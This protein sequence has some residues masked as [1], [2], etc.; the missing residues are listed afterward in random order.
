MVDGHQKPRV[1]ISSV[2]NNFQIYREIARTAVEEA[3]GDPILVNEDFPALDASPRNTCLDAVASSD[4][5]ILILGSSGGS[6]TPSGK[7][8]IEEEYEEARRRKIPVFAFLEGTERDEPAA[9]LA[10]N[11]SS[12]VEGKFRKTFSSKEELRSVIVDSLS[13]SLKVMSIP[14]TN[15]SKIQAAVQEFRQRSD[16]TRLNVVIA[17]VRDNEVIDP[18]TMEDSDFKDSLID[19]VHNRRI[20]LFPYDRSTEVSFEN[21]HIIVYQRNDHRSGNFIT[22]IVSEKGVLQVITNVVEQNKNPLNI[23]SAFEIDEQMIEKTLLSVF[24]FAAEFYKQRDPHRKYHDF[25][26]AV[27]LAGIGYKR[28]G[29]SSEKK[30]SYPMNMGGSDMVVAFDQPRHIDYADFDNPSS[31]IQ[32]VLAMLRRQVNKD[33]V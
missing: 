9:S 16:E 4:A 32:R 30:Q 12:Y 27:A 23:Q 3:G 29:R 28:M 24:S 2:L 19:L 31:E 21:G 15:T 20:K 6:V 33:V 5:F 13:Q 26:Y 22:L 14:T 11:V 1:F 18:V 10:K 8:V 25:Y 17:P 7:L